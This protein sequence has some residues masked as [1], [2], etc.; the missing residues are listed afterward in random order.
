ML[1]KILTE[2]YERDLNKLRDE[3]AQYASEEDL[4]KTSDGISN[5]AGNLCLHLTGNLK[6]FFG[7][8]IGN[9][10]YVRDRNAEFTNKN[11]SRS[12]MLADIDAT[13]NVVLQTLAGMTE[14]DLGKVYPIEVFGQPMTTGYFVTHLATHFNY[15]LGQINYHRRLVAQ[16]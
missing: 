4:W 3:I 6:H 15:H 8:I 2:L 10:G 7:A 13:R 9:S 11:I 5:S 12:E 14:E 16:A 1:R